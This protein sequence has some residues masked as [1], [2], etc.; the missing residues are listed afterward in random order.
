MVGVFAA[1]HVGDDQEI[2]RR[3]LGR[4][5]GLGND[6]RIAR[7]VAAQGI[8]LVRNAAWL[9]SSASMSGDNWHWPG[10]AAMGSLTPWP[11][12]TNNGS[13]RLAGE[14]RV[15]RTNSRTDG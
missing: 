3:L 9:I 11:G 2:A 10:I 1:A 14:S 15:S 5:D 8:L 6:A 4:A 12:R 7:G 13:I